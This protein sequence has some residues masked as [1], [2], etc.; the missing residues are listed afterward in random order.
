M[1]AD[2]L[3]TLAIE[4][5]SSDADTA[6]AG[7]VPLVELRGTL[8]AALR[9]QVSID[10]EIAPAA[11]DALIGNSSETGRLVRDGDRV[12]PAGRRAGRSPEIEAAMSR[13]EAALAVASPPP[14]AEAARAAGCP[15][16]AVRALEA[17]GR[18]TRL[19]DD[20]AWATPTLRGFEELAVRLASPG[21]L[22]PAA[23][24]DATGTS[25]RYALA[26]LEDLD[27]R[28]VLSRTSAGHV[29]GPRAG[30]LATRA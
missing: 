19:E 22:A 11:V 20:L 7:G 9:R 28:G 6:G 4:L 2:A 16:D 15:P 8:V 12:L 21:P 25:R 1:I 26:I 5:V 27:R 24:R 14:L 18:I 17:A 23:F 3:D 30:T 10:R 29:P 13:L